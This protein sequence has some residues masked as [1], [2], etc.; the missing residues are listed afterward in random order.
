VPD[1]GK[2]QTSH[3]ATMVTPL[4]MTLKSRDSAKE[5]LERELPTPVK[6][7]VAKYTEIL[8]R[9]IATPAQYREAI[10]EACEANGVKRKGVTFAPD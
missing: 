3:L 8:S 10:Y 4:V 5:R 2:L 1:S 6:D 7:L 9:P